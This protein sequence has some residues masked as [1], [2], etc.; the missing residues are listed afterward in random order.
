MLKI[1]LKKDN[2]KP[3]KK[4]FSDFKS[5]RVKGVRNWF[6]TKIKVKYIYNKMILKWFELI[7]GEGAKYYEIWYKRGYSQ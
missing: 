3:Q 5:F 7:K 6:D 2:W 1:T 4:S